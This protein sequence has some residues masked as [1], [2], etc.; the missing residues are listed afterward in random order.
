MATARGL[1]NGGMVAPTIL[2]VGFF[3]F[4]KTSEMMVNNICRSTWHQ[5]FRK[6]LTSNAEF[7]SFSVLQI[8]PGTL[9]ARYSRLLLT[10]LISG[11]IHVLMDLAR[12]IPVAQSGSMPFFTVHALG[13]MAE[14]LMIYIGTPLIGAKYAWWKRMVGYLW[15]ALFIFIT[16]PMYSYPICRGLYQAGE[17]VPS[18]YL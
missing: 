9:W 13:I 17:R 14:D 5:G 16:T 3:S 1:P 15:V 7:I 11:V 12:G 2:G 6:L 8:P 4:P 10:F 18:F